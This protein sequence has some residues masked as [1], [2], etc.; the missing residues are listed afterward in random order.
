MTAATSLSSQAILVAHFVFGCA[1]RQKE[2]KKSA[3][4]VQV[5]S[6]LKSLL[7]TV[8]SNRDRV[9][10]TWLFAGD[11]REVDVRTVRARLFSVDEVLRFAGKASVH[12]V[13]VELSFRHDTASSMGSV[14]AVQ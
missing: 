8:A 5:I 4:R 3:P 12:A 14:A 13:L 11:E 10:Q 9:N 1:G 7:I 6:R 2:M